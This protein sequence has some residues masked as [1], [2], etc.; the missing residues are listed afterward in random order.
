MMSDGDMAQYAT[1]GAIIV[2]M[3]VILYH[4]ETTVSDAMHTKQ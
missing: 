2:M 3:L 1:V 4:Y